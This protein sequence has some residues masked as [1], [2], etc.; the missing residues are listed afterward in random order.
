MA[1]RLPRYIPTPPSS[2]PFSAERYIPLLAPIC[3]LSELHQTVKNIHGTVLDEELTNGICQ[4]NKNGSVST[5]HAA[6]QVAT[7]NMKA[8]EEDCEFADE[9]M[10]LSIP[11]SPGRTDY[12]RIF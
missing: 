7:Q 2:P 6:T 12:I 3:N 10:Q 1:P 11:A 8:Y 9:H 5:A 4:A